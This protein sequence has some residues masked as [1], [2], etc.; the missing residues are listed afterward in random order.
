MAHGLRGKGS[1]VWGSG[2]VAHALWGWG[3]DQMV[4]SL[5]LN[6]VAHCLRGVRSGC[7]WSGGRG[8]GQVVHG[9]GLRSGDSWPRRRGWVRWSMI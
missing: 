3:L 1:V 4:H 2:Q 5:G 8:S 6:Q 7:S 9:L